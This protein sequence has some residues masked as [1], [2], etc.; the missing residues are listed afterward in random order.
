MKRCGIT[1]IQVII[2]AVIVVV[3]AIVGAWYYLLPP[4]EKVTVIKLGWPTPLTGPLAGFGE[5]APFVKNVYEDYV[6]NKMGGIYIEEAG[7]KVPINI[8]LRDTESDYDKAAKV[9]EELITREKVDIIVVG[10]GTPA[11]ALPASA[12]CER[13]GVPYV[14]AN[15]ALSWLTGAPYKWSYSILLMEPD[16]VFVHIGMWGLIES[17][18]VVGTLFADDIDGRVFKDCVSKLAPKD[19]KIVDLGMVSYGV[20]DYS[21]VIQKIKSENVEILYVN[22]LCPDFATFWRQCHQA[23]I[24]PKLTTTGRALFFPGD[25]EAVGG[26]LPLGVC[27]ELFWA[28]EFPYRSQVTGLTAREIA[29][30][31][32]EFSGKPWYTTLGGAFAVLDVAVDSLMRCRSLDKVKI[33]DAIA[34]TDIETP[35]GR[36]CFKKTLTEAER[37]R[38]KYWPE[39]IEYKNLYS[40]VPAVGGQWVHGT[41]FKW[42]CVIVYNWIYDEISEHPLIFP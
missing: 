16:V 7:H 12:Q 4:K 3:V 38:Y 37:E 28:P 10:W 17:N 24:K 26:D 13:Y 30:K 34:D 25:L 27:A 41:K 40:I 42:E 11:T 22:M 9:T 1:K 5:I 20:T 31:W 6:N 23:G 36:I 32:S 18:K 19:Y 21:A 8:I 35:T 14:G 33:R 29:E 15:I 39:L 2:I